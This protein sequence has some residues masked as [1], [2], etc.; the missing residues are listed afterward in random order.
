MYTKF[1]RKLVA[2]IEESFNGHC[3][4]DVGSPGTG[5]CS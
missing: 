5:H 4:G 2:K 1:L 3:R